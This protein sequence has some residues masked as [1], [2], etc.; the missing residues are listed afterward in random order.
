M[1][2]SWLVIG[3]LAKLGRGGQFFTKGGNDDALV[4]AAGALGEEGRVATVLPA[5]GEY[6]FGAVLVVERGA[7]VLGA[8]LITLGH[9]DD[10]TGLDR[11]QHTVG[12]LPC[13]N[14]G[15]NA[16]VLVVGEIDLSSFFEPAEGAD[17]NDGNE[18]TTILSGIF[19]FF[20]DDDI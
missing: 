1:V 19:H 16:G 10:L 5:T 2:N 6:D 18:L 15:P 12:V 17:T 13:G 11:G 8:D 7:D 20:H 4:V 9:R 3:P 14:Y